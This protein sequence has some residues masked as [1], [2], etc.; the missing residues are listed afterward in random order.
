MLR[1]HPWVLTVRIATLAFLLS[2]VA[3]SRAQEGPTFRPGGGPWQSLIPLGVSPSGEVY[4]ATGDPGYETGLSSDLYVSYDSGWTWRRRAV[5]FGARRVAFGD[6]VVWAATGMGLLRSADAG[7]TWTT[8]LAG[9][10]RDVAVDGDRIAAVVDG[11]A[12]LRTGGVWAPLT[13][14]PPQVGTRSLVAV[15]LRG[16]RVAV[17]GTVSSQFSTSGQAFV[18]STDGASWQS[19]GCDGAAQG[20]ALTE[21]DDLWLACA[22]GY[23]LQ[24][25]TYGGLVRSHAG[26]T[27]LVSGGPVRG[28]TLGPDGAL[29][30]TFLNTVARYPS[31][32]LARSAEGVEL[33]PL[34]VLPSGRALVGSPTV[35]IGYFPD[36]YSYTP[37]K[38]TYAVDATRAVQIG[39]VPAVVHTLWFDADLGLLAGGQTGTVLRLDGDAWVPTP[40]TQV[41]VNR[42]VDG[43][44]GPLALGALE[45]HPSWL[46]NAPG[47]AVQSV[48]GAE[49][50][51]PSYAGEVADLAVLGAA[52]FQ[53]TPYP[54]WLSEPGLWRLPTDW[55]TPM[56]VVEGSDL[57]MVRAVSGT[58]AFAGAWGDTTLAGNAAAH[59]LYRTTDSGAT[60][61]PDDSGLSAFEVFVVHRTASEQTIAGTSNGVFSRDADGLWTA[62]GLAGLRVRDLAPAP[63]GL[64]AGTSD[65]LWIRGSDG[66][67]TRYG[68]G[69]DGRTVY[70]VLVVDG[71]TPWIAAGTDAGVWATRPLATVEAAPD[72]EPG[73]RALA[74][75]PNPTAGDLRLSGVAP[76]APVFVFDALGRQ[77]A[78]AVAGPDGG[79][80]VST[81]G[82]APGVYVVRS[83][84][85]VEVRTARVTVIR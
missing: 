55:S 77:V 11:T 32:G 48:V 3:A 41:R 28:L 45:P 22:D 14:P 85:G 35:T 84:A 29:W 20:V 27:T 75:A 30:Y 73:P 23:F 49:N 7:A 2:C 82:W 9:S 24:N 40:V 76:G 60:W 65:G 70:D 37:T 15:A 53:A 38:G 78:R 52:W 42:I 47:R 54:D 46:S 44:E 39:A 13:L 25:N 43:P 59:R 80:T 4:A 8:E 6:G 33:G 31:D 64:I 58:E 61:L 16:S 56:V 17:A 36:G 74:V 34:V 69:L 66:A 12:R 19:V 68:Q 81:R 63:D 72:P 50:P 83:V 5:D 18:S 71:T 57:R 1:D 10:A 26:T 21:P 79:L 51:L 62:A 67:W